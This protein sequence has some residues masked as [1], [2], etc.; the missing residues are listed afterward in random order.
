[1]LEADDRICLP[2]LA[3]RTLE[4]REARSNGVGETLRLL[5]EVD[6]ASLAKL[7]EGEDDE[8]FADIL[9]DGRRAVDLRGDVLQGDQRL[10]RTNRHGG[11]G[12]VG[13]AQEHRHRIDG[14]QR[15]LAHRPGCAKAVHGLG[16]S[17]APYVALKQRA[18]RQYEC[19]LSRKIWDGVE[20][21]TDVADRSAARHGLDEIDWVNE[22]GCDVGTDSGCAVGLVDVNARRGTLL[23]IKSSAL[24]CGSCLW[25]HRDPQ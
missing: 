4:I 21:D 22:Y 2:C 18:F 19:P 15:R 10:H 5:V 13:D 24:C 8:V 17:A 7:Q 3:G 16:D 9:E 1:V 23:S 12:D 25:W 14:C 20:R 6:G 11:L